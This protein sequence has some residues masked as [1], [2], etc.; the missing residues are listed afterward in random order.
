MAVLGYLPK[1][2][3]GLALAFGTHFLHDFSIKMFF[4]NTLS[5]DK[6]SI[7]YRFPSQ[8]IKQNVL[9]SSY[10]D[11]WWCHKFIFDQR[12]IFDQPLKQWLRE[13]KRG[14]DRNTKIWI[15]WERKQLFRWNKKSHYYHTTYHFIIL[16]MCTINDSH[17]MYSS[18]DMKCNKQNFW[19]FSTIFCP[20]TPLTTWKIKILKNWKRHLEILSFYTCVP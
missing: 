18:W 10:L 4:F 14:E 5:M 3:T 13:A 15:S 8:D 2:K 6:V 19:S 11:S 9:K 12:F 1:L 17:M 16:Q 7:S 20:F